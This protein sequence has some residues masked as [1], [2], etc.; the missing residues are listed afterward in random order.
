MM[1]TPILFCLIPDFIYY[2]GTEAPNIPECMNF[3]PIEIGEGADRAELLFGALTQKQTLPLSALGTESDGYVGGVTVVFCTKAENGALVTVGWYENANVTETPNLP[4][5]E[6]EDGGAHDHPFFFCCRREN[7][8]L[9]PYEDRF[10]PIWAIPRNK[11]GKK[12]KFGF[13]SDRVWLCDEGEAASWR[14]G[15]LSQLQTY[16]GDNVLND[17]EA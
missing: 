12:G 2:D 10:A 8:V 5:C 15:F 3:L 9:L 11:S 13:S 17:S 14:D 16:N 7:A 6:N 4:P 1:N